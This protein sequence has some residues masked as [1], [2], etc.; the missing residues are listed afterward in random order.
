MAQVDSCH[1][2]KLDGFP[3]KDRAN[4]LASSSNGHI[5]TLAI[6]L[7]IGQIKTRVGR[8]C[9]RYTHGIIMEGSKRSSQPNATVYPPTIK[10]RK[11]F[12]ILKPERI[13]DPPLFSTLKPSDNQKNKTCARGLNFTRR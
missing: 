4:P 13:D 2:Q 10:S 3:Y 7:F 9:R 5:S 8:H 11:L 6:L 1:T 12:F